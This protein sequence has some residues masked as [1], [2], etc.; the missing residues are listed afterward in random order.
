MRARSL[1]VVLFALSLASLP[2]SSFAA[3]AAPP[4]LWARLR[5]L[6]GEWTG[7][8]AGS[9]G[10]GGGGSTFALDLDDRIM[11]RHNRA[12]Y[13]ATSDRAAFSHR[14]LLV[15]YPERDSTFRAIYWDNEGHVIRYRLGFGDAPGKVTF[16]SEGPEQAP[17]FRLSYELKPDGAL[18][19]GFDTSPPGGALKRYVTGTLRRV[20]REKGK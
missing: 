9:P 11:V 7:E 3:G 6:L 14:D 20:P 16:D 17:R 15:V 10:A 18:E 8:G 13:P 5:F 12:D 1:A 4:D 2:T 19:V